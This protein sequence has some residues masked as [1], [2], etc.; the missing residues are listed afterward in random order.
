MTKKREIN[1]E[2]ISTNLVDKSKERKKRQ[3]VREKGRNEAHMEECYNDLA[4]HV[5]AI[6]EEEVSNYIQIVKSSNCGRSLV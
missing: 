5:V 2:T 3:L 1:M 4:C 6:H